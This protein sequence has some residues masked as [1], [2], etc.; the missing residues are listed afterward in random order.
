LL[1]LIAA[2]AAYGQCARSIMQA[3]VWRNHWA[4][5]NSP[6]GW[7]ERIDNRSASCLVY[8]ALMIDRSM[9]H[10]KLDSLNPRIRTE[11][12]G[13]IVSATVA[14]TGSLRRFLY[15]TLIAA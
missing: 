12:K 5:C 2:K 8:A 6:L 7:S 10:R 9:N 4:S 11:W 13:K 3:G 15:R 1:T 14:Q